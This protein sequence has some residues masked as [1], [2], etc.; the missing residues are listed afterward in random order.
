M[1]TTSLLPFDTVQFDAE[2]LS[3]MLF[4]EKYVDNVWGA[5]PVGQTPLAP[6]WR[7]VLRGIDYRG[8][9]V[10]VAFTYTNGVYDGTRI[11]WTGATPPATD[12][13]PLSETPS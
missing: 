4:N 10:R 1:S 5:Y 8:V 11:V 12:S 6:E 2:H 13:E 7:L 9:E 3:A